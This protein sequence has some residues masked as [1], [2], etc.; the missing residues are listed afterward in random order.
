MQR[1]ALITGVAGFLGSN[2]AELLMRTGYAVV[3]FDNLCTGRLRNIK[4]LVDH[5]NF[6][7]IEKDICEHDC[8]ESIDD[9]D[10]IYNFACPASPPRYT[11]LS[12]ETLDVCYLGTK[13]VIALA[14]RN[15]ARIVHASTSE[16]YGDPCISPQS[17][18]YYGNV[19]PYGPRAC[20]DEGKRVAEALLFEAERL[21]DI[22]VT[23]VRI[24]NTFGP[25]MEINDGRVV[26]NFIRNALRGLP[27][28]VYGEGLQTRSL[29]YVD[30][31]LEGIQTLVNKKANGIF[32]VGNDR[33][34]TIM[35]I[36]DIIQNICGTDCGYD[37]HPLPV[38]DPLQRCPDLTKI[39]KLGWSA[40]TPLEMALEKTIRY[41]EAEI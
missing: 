14:K 21:H 20:Y 17:E 25:N 33:E 35:E 6:N 1:K 30:D 39:K 34:L 19:N 12:I 3:G 5:S 7:F 41:L 4:H 15:D 24:F 2:L 31:L 11:S 28:T 18:T 40:N 10:V 8:F 32:N 26:T 23:L 13:N 38:N 16:V 36:G 22:R 37:Y 27:L 29:C 9:V